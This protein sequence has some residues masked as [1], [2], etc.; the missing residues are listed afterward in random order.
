MDS[1]LN[2][3]EE[4]ADNCLQAYLP[5]TAVNKTPRTVPFANCCDYD[6]PKPV[7]WR[8]VEPT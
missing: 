4:A 3:N 1:V 5:V 2:L 7:I 6:D 8:S